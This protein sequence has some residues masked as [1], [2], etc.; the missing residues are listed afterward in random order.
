[1]PVLLIA[2]FAGMVALALW[3]WVAAPGDRRFSVRSG[4]P[5]S[6][7][8][9]LGKRTGLVVWVVLGAVVTTGSLMAG[10]DPEGDPGALPVAGAAL[11]VFLLLMEIVSVRRMMR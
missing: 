11:L 6:L 10:A 1:M 9:T 7:D 5:P 2:L 4:N 8:G 3:T